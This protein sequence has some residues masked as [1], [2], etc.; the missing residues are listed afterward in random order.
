[1]M[2]NKNNKAHFGDKRFCLLLARQKK[3]PEASGR[4]EAGQRQM[5]T[6]EISE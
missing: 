1:M 4:L 5:T 3:D 6:I 2:P